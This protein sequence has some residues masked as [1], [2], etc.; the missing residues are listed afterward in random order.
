[1]R[2]G[3]ALSMAAPVTA[4]CRFGAFMVSGLASVSIHHHEQAACQQADA[5]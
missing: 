3:A 2:F 5:L 4:V 1:L